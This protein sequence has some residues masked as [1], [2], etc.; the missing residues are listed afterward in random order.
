M[1]DLVYHHVDVFTRTPFSGNSLT[2][3]LNE[4]G[5]TSVQMLAITQEMQH[6]ESVFLER[7]DRSDTVR[8]RIFD[9]F[10]ELDF[11]GHPLLGA[12][13]VLHQL[14]EWG[15]P[16]QWCFVLNQ[17]TVTVRSWRTP[18]GFRV[19]LD[20]G[21]PEFLGIVN[22]AFRGEVAKALNLV[23]ADLRTD[24]ELEVVST[25]LS[26]LIVP[27]RSGLSGAKIARPDFAQL[28][29]SVGAEFAYVLDVHAREGRHWNNDGVIDDVA[30][31]SA[32]GTVGAYLVKHGHM[33]PNREFILHQG[34]FAGRP[35]EITVVAQGNQHEITNVRVSG[36]VA[37]V[38][39]GKMSRPW[40][41]RA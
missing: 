35:S 19:E 14:D 22:G 20:Q 17:K 15:D 11:A 25:G 40:A 24:C 37:H 32:A 6:F 7:T 5:L 28:L 33:P 30:T 21:R 2:V 31:G 1:S 36:A 34:R 18:D 26:Y 38:G 10:G 8:V 13:A 23:V 41:G 39:S 16:Q 9:L 3:F 4:N 27:I 12:A 29:R